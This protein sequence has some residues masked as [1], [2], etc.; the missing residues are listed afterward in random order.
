MNGHFER[1]TQLA[2]DDAQGFISLRRTLIAELI[3]H[4][5]MNS[6]DLT[7]LQREIDVRLATSLAPRQSIDVM[8][9]LLEERVAALKHLAK[10]LAQLRAAS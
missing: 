4:P 10:K 9:E 6:G 2:P 8:M 1:L 7:T 5:A 3:D